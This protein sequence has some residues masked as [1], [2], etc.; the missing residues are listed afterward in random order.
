VTRTPGRRGCPACGV[1]LTRANQTKEH[2][3]SD[4]LRKYGVAY[5]AL[6]KSFFGQRSPIPQTRIVTGVDGRRQYEEVA[7][8]LVSDFLATV[9]MPVCS[10]CN[11]TWMSQIEN[12]AKEELAPVFVGGARELTRSGRTAIATWAALTLVAYS[13]A[14]NAEETDPIPRS[15]LSEIRQDNRPPDGW[16]IWIGF[17]PDG[18]STQMSA[19]IAGLAFSGPA[20]DLSEPPP[21][22]FANCY[23]AAH[24]VYFIAHYAAP[25]FPTVLYEALF[26]SES[27][28]VLLPLWPNTPQT[29]ALRWPQAAVDEE[30]AVAHSTHVTRVV[31][32]IGLPEEGLNQEEVAG[33]LEEFRDGAKPGELRDNWASEKP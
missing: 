4:W 9:T 20:D 18:R 23:L 30:T 25:S 27:R 11:N 31:E 5:P 33:V 26:P 8:P 24:G 16:R 32:A 15:Q 1:V 21:D 12:A 7:G 28:T 6:S 29:Q 17:C 3:W 13:Q 19:A 2:V 22:N 10:N 14:R